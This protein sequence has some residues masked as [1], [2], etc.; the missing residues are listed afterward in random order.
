M[1]SGTE[2]FA[3]TP[4]PPR[5][6]IASETPRR[7]S[8]YCL[9]YKL[10]AKQQSLGRLHGRVVKGVGHLG[11]GEAMEA[12]GRE[13]NPRPGQCSRT[14]RSRQL[15]QFYHLNVSFFQNS[16]FIWNIVLVG[17]Q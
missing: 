9:R 11:H 8:I 2:L 7:Q 15:M 13:F 16:E 4:V 14:S 1:A 17:K 12:G 10:T 3:H 5:T 6:R